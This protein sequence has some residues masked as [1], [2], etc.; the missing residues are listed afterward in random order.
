MN[1]E[2]IYWKVLKEKKKVGIFIAVV[3]VPKNN[4]NV[5][6]EMKIKVLDLSG[7]VINW[8]LLNYWVFENLIDFRNFVSDHLPPGISENFL[9]TFSS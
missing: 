9:V 1:K 6:E 5:E 2:L 4:K 3:T 7:V 8:L